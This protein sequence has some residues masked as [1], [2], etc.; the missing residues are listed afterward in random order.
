MRLQDDEIQVLRALRYGGDSKVATRRVFTIVKKFTA[1]EML[2]RD[3]KLTARG[4]HVASKLSPLPEPERK[5]EEI[6]APQ[7]ELEIELIDETDWD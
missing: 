3:G 5:P 7:P 4:R 6:P 1:H 2:D